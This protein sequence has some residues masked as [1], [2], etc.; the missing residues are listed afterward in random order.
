MGNKLILT[1][2]MK[3]ALFIAAASALSTGDAPPYFNQPTWNENMPS[4]AGL[5]QVSACWKAGSIPDVSCGP[6]N[7]ELFATGM[8]GDEDLGQDITMKGEKF[9]YQQQ[10]LIALNGEGDAAAEKATVPPPEK[11]S[12]LDPKIAKTH[13]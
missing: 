7:I 4:A 13:T 6:T 3:S 12:I 10:Q 11:V 2:K 5:L 1:I 8:N 9:H